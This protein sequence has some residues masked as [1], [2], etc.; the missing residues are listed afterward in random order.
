MKKDTELDAKTLLDLAIYAFLR[1]DGAWFIETA[2]KFGVEAAT[3]LDIKAWESFSE[4][5]GRKIANTL[6][7]QGNFHD[8]F[9]N[10]MKIQNTVMNMKTEIIPV[11]ENQFLFR[12]LDCEVWKMVSKKWTPETAPCYKVTQAS[13]Q[14][15]LRGAFPGLKIEIVQKKM[16]PKGDPYCEVEITNKGN[17]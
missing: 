15:L 3:E 4:R 13:I 11:N 12:T 10:V 17:N 9:L 5:L 1:L 2:A 16:I 14:G 7:L 6:N 8:E